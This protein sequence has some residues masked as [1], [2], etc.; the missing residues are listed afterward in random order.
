MPF[1]EGPFV[2]EKGLSLFVNRLA[3]ASQSQN[4]VRAPTRIQLYGP[5]VFQGELLSRKCTPSAV[6]MH[7]WYVCPSRC[8][9]LFLEAIMGP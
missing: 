8:H 5:K 7:R 9:F 3:L 1:D 2:V 4:V 6:C